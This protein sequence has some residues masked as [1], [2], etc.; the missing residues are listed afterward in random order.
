M[1]RQRLLPNRS[2]TK[3]SQSPRTSRSPKSEKKSGA[4]YSSIG[5]DISNET[6]PENQSGELSFRKTLAF[7]RPYIIPRSRRHQVIGAVSVLCTLLYKACLLVPGYAM[8]IAVDALSSEDEHIRT[9]RPLIGALAYFLGRFF[10]AFFGQGQDISLE[11][12]TQHMARQFAKDSFEHLQSLSMSY[13]S[14]KRTGETTSIL[15]RGIGSIQTLMK[16]IVFS[17]GP[18]L[19]EA[20]V[21]S[22]IFF[23]LGSPLIAFCTGMTVIL[24]VLYTGFITKWRVR[25]GRALREAENKA[26]GR[27]TESI[28]NFATVKSFGMEYSEVVRYDSLR[29]VVQGISLKVKGINSAYA[30]GQNFIVQLGT[31]LG[32]FLAAREAIVG[33]ISAGDFIMVQAYIGQLFGPLLWLGNSYGQVVTALTEVEQ[34]MDLFDTIPEVQDAVGAQDLTYSM[35]DVDNRTFGSISFKNV[36]FLYDKS[37]KLSG[38]ISNVSFHVP[39]GKMVA[40][41]GASGAG[42]S[43]IGKLLLRL[44][45]V[46]SGSV[47]ID[48]KDIRGLTQVSLRKAIGLVA[49]ETI[50]FNDTVRNNITYGMPEANDAQVWEAVRMASLEKFVAEQSLGLDTVVGER[51]VRLSGGER[52]RVGIARAILK[53][54]GIMMLDESTSALSTIDERQIQENLRTVCTGRTTVAIAHRLSTVMMAEEILVIKDGAV[55]ERG[56][57]DELVQLRGIYG[58]MWRIQSGEDASGTSPFWPQN[59]HSPQTAIV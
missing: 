3:V 40:L 25:F 20:A 41:V 15:G 28:M 14:K 44:Y 4:S 22:G 7:C 6:K 53:Q 12:C 36:S 35:Q 47:T 43:T 29:A 45:D 19:L 2:E 37:D 46:E 18:T 26:W 49:Q 17:L 16:L 42:K 11:Y 48:G 52:Q 21:V 58:D 56:N 8:K 1:E 13:H 27:A 54:P 30:L 31:F 57:H 50:L 33:N 9:T 39:A 34:I 38:G 51:G 10:A 32:L 5:T 23:K 59:A 55:V 24:Y